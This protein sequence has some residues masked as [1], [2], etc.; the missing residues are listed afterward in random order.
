MIVHAMEKDGLYYLELSFGQN[1]IENQAPL[2]FLFEMPSTLK[3]NIWLHHCRLGHS[4]FDVLKIM[5][6]LL[7]KG[8]DVEKLY[9]DVCEFAKNHCASFQISNKRASIPFA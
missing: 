5:F 3:N 8:I 1:K 2:L 7:F 4:L 6:P 9:C